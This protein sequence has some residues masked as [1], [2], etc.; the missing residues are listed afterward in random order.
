MAKGYGASGDILT[1]TRDG[2]DLN[3]IWQQYQDALAAF[4]SARQPLIDLLS[5]TVTTNI[6]DVVQPGQEQFEEATEF[7][8]P[9]G[10]RPAP[11][12]V[13][14]GFPFKWYDTR[15]AYTF[16]FLAGGPNNSDGASSQQLDA[17]LQQVMEADNNLQF[18]LTMKAIF[19]NVNR[20]IVIDGFA[21]TAT[22]L[23][24]AD[25]VYPIP[26][27]RGTTF[28]SGSHTH[29]TFSGTNAGQV[30]FDPGDHIQLAG[31]VEEHGYTRSNGYNVVFLMNG[32]D[33]AAGIQ[34]FVRNQAFVSGGAT[35]V[36]SLYD[37]I[38]SAGTNLAIQLPPGYTLV[39]G[40]PPNSFAG[41]DVLGSWGNYLIVTDAQIPVGYMVAVALKG[42]GVRS[43]VVGI[44]EHANAAMRGVVLRP[45]N[46]QNYPLID[47]FYI[48][49]MGTAIGPRG[50]A[51]VMKLDASGGAY[52]VPAS[53][54]W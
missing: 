29:Y 2:Q 6:E 30:A 38:P 40:I 41:L 17:I 50:A 19:N 45:G 20:A 42:A 25:G 18:Q 44:R 27:Y 43:N 52:T 5:Y 9:Q 16:Q 36:S 34:K 35:T 47:S 13:A 24:N 3:T 22:A 31:L 46:N 48:R 53:M 7:G 23:Y 37:F 21:T 11:A 51:A 12:P 54:V 33:A 32:T 4:N 10:I 8:I 1:R 15:S 28:A 49:G 39:G 26:S 14:R